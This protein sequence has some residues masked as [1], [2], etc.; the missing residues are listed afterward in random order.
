MV[1]F[2]LIP[3][4]FILVRLVLRARG[5]GPPVA[6]PDPR[7]L[8]WLI[9][10]VM[11]IAA[12]LPLG[13]GLLATLGDRITLL[14]ATLLL[15]YLAAVAAV[16]FAFRTPWSL[17]HPLARRGHHRLVY[18]L[19]QLSPLFIASG[20]T[21]A[22]GLLL[23]ALALSYRPSCT[24]IERSF[25]ERRLAKDRRGLAAFGSA[26]ALWH[27]LEARAARD[28]GDEA[29]AFELAESAR[30]LFGT[31]TYMSHRAAPLPVRRVAEEYLAL[32]SARR[33]LWG[34]LG[35]LPDS[36]ARPGR[37]GRL[38]PA[39]QALR[40][41]F[42]ERL[43]GEP[44]AR[45]DERVLARMQSPIVS[46]LFARE[47]R[48]AGAGLP[49][50]RAQAAAAYLT[51]LR[52]KPVGPRATLAMLATFDLLLDPA[53]PGT[54]LPREIQQDGELLAAVQDDTAATLAEVIAPV[55]APL[56]AMKHFGPVSAR[57]HQRVEV[58]LF[59]ELAK[60]L[61]RL[62]A[63]RAEGARGD[64][65]AEW[66]EVSHVRARYRRLQ[67]TLGSAAAGRVLQGL[68]YSYGNLGVDMTAKT[69]LRRPLAHAIFGMLR[70]EAVLFGHQ[71]SITLQTSNM[72]ATAGVR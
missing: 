59:D 43:E 24:A 7:R 40:A 58:A 56:S 13:I 1:P 53:A 26:L 32:D 63:R 29:R 72:K 67:S 19:A 4:A 11:G 47:E 44:R 27:A 38:T 30:A 66:L 71:A 6:M 68:A 45:E 69:P 57:V 35:N 60:S 14:T 50:A 3:V 49:A 12:A 64:A 39:G 62:D 34:G 28:A 61:K 2:P 9:A 23:S 46:R 21:A 16:A 33:G 51:L 17:L 22:G 55:G 52:R 10:L 15:G 8:A 42:R 48:T 54:L 41:F 37:R 70:G 65:R 20:E 25:L 31:V 18:Y 5:K 36:P